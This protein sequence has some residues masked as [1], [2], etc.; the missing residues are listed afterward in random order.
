MNKN[1]NEKEKAIYETMNKIFTHKILDD[2]FDRTYYRNF[3]IYVSSDEESANYY[4]NEVKSFFIGKEINRK[5]Q[6]TL[7][8]FLNHSSLYILEEFRNINIRKK[9]KK[10]SY[11]NKS[12]KEQIEWI[13]NKA[14]DFKEFL[15]LFDFDMFSKNKL[16][17]L[18]EIKDF[19][20]FMIENP[21]NFVHTKYSPITKKFLK[22][23][24]LD[25]QPAPLKKDIDA[26][27]TITLDSVI[28]INKD[29]NN[30]IFKAYN[31]QDALFTTPLIQK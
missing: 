29:F 13:R 1:K 18:F 21:E 3:I 28:N 26:F 15:S 27:L 31:I 22:E 2:F 8:R 17:H 25:L 16:Y 5:N 30:V 14:K 7:Y 20:D 12:K 10:I 24:L 6:N 4:L 9:A 11:I 23:N 19:L